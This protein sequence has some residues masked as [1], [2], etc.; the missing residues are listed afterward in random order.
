V[1]IRLAIVGPGKVGQVLARGFAAAGVDVLGFV[2]RDPGRAAAA[3]ARC[4]TGRA[5]DVSGLA[6]AHVVVFAVGD[7]QLAE[8][9]A[10]CAGAPPRACSL[11]LHTSGR[12]GLE[13]LDPLQGLEC[14]LGALHPVAPFTSTT[15]ASDLRGQPAVLLGSPGAATLLERLCDLLGMRPLWSTGGDR[16][17]YHA[18]CALAANGLTALRDA[19]DAA[20]HAAGVLPAPDADLLASALMGSALSLCGSVGPTAALSGPA[21]RGDV[22]T[23]ADHRRAIERLAP[24]ALPAYLALMSH[25]VA[26]A[27]RR[28]LSATEAAALRRELL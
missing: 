16:L 19:V 24:S 6:T 28:G 23:V 1:P 8:A 21:V 5:L 7:P 12:F 25:A 27:E 2:G 3:A 20:L 26:I 4:G 17:L 10:A 22:E 9:V 14:R 18:A 13:V 11:W 15:A